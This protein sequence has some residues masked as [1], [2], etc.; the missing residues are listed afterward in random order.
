VAVPPSGRIRRPKI[1]A[2]ISFRVAGTLALVVIAV[3]A[4]IAVRDATVKVPPP[5]P[6][7]TAIVSYGPVA[8]I[9]RLPGRLSVDST[10]RIGSSQ[11]GLVVAVTAAAGKRVAKG[12]VL[13][14]L[15]DAEQR[16][17]AAGADAR[18]ASAELLGI[19]AEREFLKELEQQ[20]AEGLRPAL[21]PDELLEGK[22][23]D[24]QLEM[25]HD[26]A[27]ISRHEHALSLARTMLARR[28]IRAPID[29]IVL[30]RNIEAGESIPA[31]P[32]GPPL[33]V[34]GSDPRRLRLEVEVDERYLHT[35]LPG[36][37]SFVVP[38]Q[39]GRE[40]AG[41]IREVTLSPTAL[42]S[43]APYVV[44]ADV[45]NTD[46]ALQPGMSAVVDLAMATGRDALSVP[47]AALT[48]EGES[49]IA[50][51]SD[52]SGRPTPTPVTTGVANVDFT[53]IR[54]AG[55]EAGRIVVSDASPSTCVVAPPVPPFAG[56]LP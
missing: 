36:R 37:A 11:A 41:T 18:L 33:F 49:T 24:A 14:R 2:R 9:L 25:L 13:A 50:W 22:A 10:V 21:P 42:R 56:R 54:G 45:A 19:R 43:P 40:F 29:G 35:V 28:T 32:P 26:A 44:V 1:R 3:G 20:E 48:T 6:C 53:E 38:A 4:A 23:G 16:A 7:T 12:E 52:G 30:A 8:G 55:V 31:S 47:T 39:G 17:A 27:Q 5:R 15:D 46:G 51:L 34:I